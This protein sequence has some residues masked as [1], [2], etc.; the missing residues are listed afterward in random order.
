[1]AQPIYD[2]VGG[3][4]YHSGPLQI[5]EYVTDEAV[6]QNGLLRLSSAQKVRPWNGV[7]KIAGVAM[8]AAGIGEKV[9]VSVD[10]ETLYEATA[11]GNVLL[12]DIGKM[13]PAVLENPSVRVGNYST[14]RIAVG[15]AVTT[16]ALT[17]PVLV[18]GLSSNVTNVAQASNHK[19]LVKLIT[20]E[21]E[22]YVDAV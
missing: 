7:S 19:C 22:P 18:I 8:H 3:F 5:I 21:F 4:K 14:M 12:S 6:Y 16:P 11:Y 1:M 10:P 17:H 13:C 15:S 20:G 2:V 9:A